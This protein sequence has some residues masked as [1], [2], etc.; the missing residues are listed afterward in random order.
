MRNSAM[1]AISKKPRINPSPRT[2]YRTLKSQ[3]RSNQS[4][5]LKV[6]ISKLTYFLKSIGPK[7]SKQIPKSQLSIDILVSVRQWFHLI[8]VQMKMHES[9]KN[10]KQKEFRYDKISNETS[11]CCSAF[12][13]ELLS[14]AFSE[15]L[16][17]RNVIKMP[18]ISK[19]FCLP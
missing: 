11:K 17:K 1:V 18:E 8:Q 16:K 12:V 6:N 3:T 19:S 5:K 7:L 9:F 14:Q 2:I 15:C 10:E 13:E 4:R